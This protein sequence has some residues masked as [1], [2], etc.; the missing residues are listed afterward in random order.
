[1]FTDHSHSEY[2][3]KSICCD[4]S[5]FALVDSGSNHQQAGTALIKKPS[6][7]QEEQNESQEID[8][9]GCVLD[10]SSVEDGQ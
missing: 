8:E 9:A 5:S 1:M 7:I 4:E 3:E 6:V 2:V 10:S